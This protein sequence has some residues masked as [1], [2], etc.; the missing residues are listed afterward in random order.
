MASNK[1]FFSHATI[2][3]NLSILIFLSIL[4]VSFAGL[5]QIV[6]LFYQHST[7]K[8]APGV[9]PLNALQLVGRDVFIKEGCVGCHSQQ[10]RVLASDV[11]RYG[12]YS[13][14]GESVYDYPFLWGSRRMG[15]DLARVGGRYS[16]DWHRIHIRDPRMVVK[17][18]NMPA[19]YWLQHKDASNT[20]IQNRMIALN[21]LNQFHQGEPM[22]SEKEIADAPNMIKGKTEED[23]VIAYLQS[24]GVGYVTALREQ[25]IKNKQ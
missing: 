10:V 1:K 11:Q 7:T 16:D 18:S 19:Y 21:K 5:V 4:V 20:N 17:Q 2:E 23:A 14:A 6:P 25:E 22:Y 3:K 12:P 9:K 15:P 24:L 13:V 8:A